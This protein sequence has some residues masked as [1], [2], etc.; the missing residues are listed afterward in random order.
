M[1]L[2]RPRVEEWIDIIYGIFTITFELRLFETDEKDGLKS[3][4]LSISLS[5][6]FLGGFYSL[7]QVKFKT[8]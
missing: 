1:K 2:E 8:F 3:G 5:I 7:R 6:F 4:I